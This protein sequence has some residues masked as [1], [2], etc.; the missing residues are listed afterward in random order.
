VR[1]SSE[2]TLT[3]QCESGR[4]D[5]IS[6]YLMPVASRREHTGAI[7]IGSNDPGHRHQRAVRCWYGAGPAD[8]SVSQLI[9][10]T[11]AQEARPFPCE[12]GMSGIDLLANPSAGESLSQPEMVSPKQALAARC[13]HH[14]TGRWFRSEGY[15]MSGYHLAGSRYNRSWR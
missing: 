15:S 3:G 4:P 9:S 7:V 13:G 6:C 11:L 10:D 5:A 14:D 2:G 12:S 1:F 8:I